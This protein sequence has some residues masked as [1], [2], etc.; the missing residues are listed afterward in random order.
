MVLII[1]KKVY[2]EEEDCFLL[3]L[4]DKYGVDMEGIYEKICDE[5]CD[6]LLFWFDWFFLSCMFI[7]L[8]CCCNIFFIIVVKEFEDVNMMIKINGMNGKFKRELEDNEEND[9][10]SIFGLVLVKKKS[11]VNGVKV[12]IFVIGWLMCCFYRVLIKIL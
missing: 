11:K 8:G 7:E 1:N 2:I 12:S 3:V 10:D 9:E 4:F 6:S 5:I